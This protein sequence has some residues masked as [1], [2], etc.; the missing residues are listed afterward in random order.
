MKA[1]ILIISFYLF[2]YTF[3]LSYVRLPVYTYH[4]TPPRINET[5]KKPY[6]T[7]FHDNN[8]YTVL[9]LGN[10]SQKI[11]TK[12]NF[13]DYPFFIY[14]NRC[15][16]KSYFDLNISSTYEKTPFQL[17]SSDIYVF[18]YQ[19]KDYFKFPNIDNTYKLNY[20]F[21]PVNKDDFE[22]KIEKLP[23]TCAV[24]GLKLSN[25]TLKS[26]NY[27]FIRELKKSTL[28]NDYTYF[29]EYNKDNP[30]EGNI[31]FGVEPHEYDKDKYIEEQM[32]SISTSQIAY[33]LYWQLQFNEIYF[34]VKN[35]KNELNRIN[36]TVLDVGLNHNLNIM[37]A[38]IDYLDE[39]EKYFFTKEKIKT[40]CTKNRLDNNFINFDCASKDD[41]KDFPTIYLVHRTLGYIFN[42]TYE[43]A[44]IEYNGRYHCLIWIDMRYRQNWRMGKP[45]LK[46]YFFSYN[47]EKKIINFYDMKNSGTKKEEREKKEKE[48]EEEENKNDIAY[49]ILIAI[50]LLAVIGLS[51]VLTRIFCK[52]G[53]KKKQANLLQ[54]SDIMPIENENEDNNGNNNTN[55]DNNNIKVIN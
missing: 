46:K 50:L 33:D 20:L 41:I 22:R 21:S 2:Q 40:N 42:I 8:I 48:K 28:I 38:P 25:P 36:I 9:E 44:F 6:Y 32:V 34:D 17:I 55:N 1:L 39:I 11:V 53:T 35:D 31:I 26:Y 45:F 3:I 49:I 30:D 14:Y 51:F 16:I 24:L 52:K 37:I 10:P 13:D 19:V 29:I 4:T 15:E 47:G 43:D 54:D 12:L 18:T 23:Y 27:S 7:Y 5:L